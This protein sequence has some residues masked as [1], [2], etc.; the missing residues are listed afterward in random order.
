MYSLLNIFWLWV[1]QPKNKLSAPKKICMPLRIYSRAS[2]IAQRVA[3]TNIPH[4]VIHKIQSFII[5][6]IIPKEICGN[7][8]VCFHNFSVVFRA[9]VV[10]V[11][12]PGKLCVPICMPLTAEHTGIFCHA[13][14]AVAITSLWYSIMGIYKFR[15]RT[16]GTLGPSECRTTHKFLYKL[17]NLNPKVLNF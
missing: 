2:K 15:P 5:N 3:F 16:D 4:N 6:H 7:K 17:K 11:P 10:V 9:R 12:F 13:A 8:K 1:R 14:A